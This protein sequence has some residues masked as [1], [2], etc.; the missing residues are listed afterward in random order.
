[1]NYDDQFKQ[2]EHEL[3]VMYVNKHPKSYT[4]MNV[5]ESR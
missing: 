5:V 4:S 2:L 3:I 1:M